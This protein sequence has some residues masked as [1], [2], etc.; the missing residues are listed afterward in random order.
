[1]DHPVAFGLLVPSAYG[2]VLVNRYD[3]DQTDALIKTGHALCHDEIA[4]L[5]AFLRSAPERALALD[6]G[7]N[8]GLYALAFARALAGKKGRV[9]AFEA[10]RLI[11][12]L[13][14]GTAAMNGVENLFIHHQAV[15]A[16]TG[17]IPIP[18]FNYN[19]AASFGS[20]EFGPQQEEFIGQ[21][22]R[23]DP[24]A[25][26]FVET[27]RLDDLDLTYVHLIK[28][29]VEGMDEAVVEG[30]SRLIERDK[31]VL[32]IEWLKADKAKLVRSCKDRGYRTYDWG[33]NLLCLH[34]DKQP[35]YKVDIPIPEL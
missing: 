7:A 24:D 6:V 21:E 18:Q 30:G 15:G 14:A 34:R 19:E 4:L 33:I 5:C 23:H 32:F 10:Q 12:Y 13:M 27:V 1:M 17:R 26:E 9:H 16:E 29:D 3:T 35:S 11:A 28:I 20:V 22:R 25:E 2:P 31:P 8:Y